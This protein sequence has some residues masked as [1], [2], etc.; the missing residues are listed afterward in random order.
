MGKKVQKT[1]VSG[2][3]IYEVG[4]MP[5]GI[6]YVHSGFAAHV[7]VATKSGGIA[8]VGDLRL[9]K[10]QV[11]ESLSGRIFCSTSHS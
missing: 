8:D 7:A 9:F 1:N 3:F 10:L 11:S 6:F 2:D 4:S 5:S